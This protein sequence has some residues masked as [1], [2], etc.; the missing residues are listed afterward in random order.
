MLMQLIEWLRFTITIMLQK[1]IDNVS[2]VTRTSQEMNLED[3]NQYI[4]TWSGPEFLAA[5]LS[6]NTLSYLLYN[7]FIPQGSRVKWLLHL[8]T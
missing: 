7:K 3:E 5:I 2:R 8:W 4:L 6:E 1:D